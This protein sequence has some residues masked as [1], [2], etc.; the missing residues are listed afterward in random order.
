MTSTLLKRPFTIL[1]VDDREENLLALEEMLEQDGR[2][3]IKATSGNEALRYALKNDQIGLIMLDVQMPGMDGFEVARLLKTNPKTRHISI[4]FVTAISKEEQ[5]ILKGFDEGAVDYL[6]K[7]LDINVTKAKVN[8]F[9]RLYQ[10]QRELK[11]TIGEVEKI[12]KQLEKFVYIVAHDLKSPLTGMIGALSLL[13]QRESFKLTP[14][15]VDEY[16]RHSKDAST[17]LSGMINALL[18]YS[19]KSI[20]QQSIEEVDTQELVEQIARLLFPPRRIKIRIN[21]RLPV[22]KTNKIKLQQ[23]FQNLLSNAVKYHDKP[24]GY[25]DVSCQDNGDFI[26][27]YVKDNGPGIPM[28][29]QQNIFRL[30][31]TSV[32]HSG[33]DTSTGVGLSILKL[34]VEEQG[35]QIKLESSPENGSLFSFDWR[36]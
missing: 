8:V 32:N 36:K 16:I 2:I 33:A 23:V 18:D 4:I 29:D 10:Y 6:Q 3:F 5:Y 11:E 28:E 17:Y 24:D 34:I 15:D 12:N 7:P 35:G 13:E 25:V 14:D 31:Q 1:L 26:T 27:F 21:G 22:L 9:E 20:T 30:F 19:R